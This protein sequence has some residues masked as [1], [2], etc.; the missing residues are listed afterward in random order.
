MNNAG[1]SYIPLIGDNE[2]QT[3]CQKEFS[4]VFKEQYQY[5]SEVLENWQKAP[6]LIDGKYL[7]NFS[8]DYKDCHFICAD[9]ASRKAGNEKGELHDFTGGTWPWFKNDI[10]NCSKSKKENI[11]IMTHIGM[12][13]TGFQV[14]DQFLFS[15][16]KMKKIKKFLYPYREYIDSNYAGH[17]HQNWHAVVFSDWFTTLYHVRVTDETWYDT[18]W[19][20]SNDHELT[21]RWV[22]VNNS[23]STILY[24][25]HIEDV[26]KNGPLEK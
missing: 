22:H 17:I 9:F 20:A 1:I 18:R 11:V 26:G 14:A 16:S 13:R 7:Q 8:F 12:F 23:G 25:Q 10:E 5:L 19:P 24:D 4:D 3:G 6:F 15:K 2:V 21:V